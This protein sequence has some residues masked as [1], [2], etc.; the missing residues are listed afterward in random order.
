MEIGINSKLRKVERK[1][2]LKKQNRTALLS[3]FSSKTD[4]ALWPDKIRI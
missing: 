2:G 1:F 3:K 4:F